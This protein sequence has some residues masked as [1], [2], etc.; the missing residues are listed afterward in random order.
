M[1]DDKSCIS[2]FL[3]ILRIWLKSRW[4]GIVYLN[5]CLQ[6]RFRMVNILVWKEWIAIMTGRGGG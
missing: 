2:T 6:Q 5:L 1:E 4:F 3:I